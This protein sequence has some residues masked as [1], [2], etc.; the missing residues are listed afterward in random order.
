LVHQLISQQRSSLPGKQPYSCQVIRIKRPWYSLSFSELSALGLQLR[1]P[2]PSHWV[3]AF[4]GFLI[5]TGTAGP[6]YPADV[7]VT[8]SLLAR[9][10]YSDNLFYSADDVLED[11]ITRVE[12]KLQLI[13]KTEKSSLEVST[14]FPVYTYA[15]NHELNHVDQYYDL[16]GSLQFTP[17]TSISASAGYSITSSNDRDVEETGITLDIEKR[18]RQTYSIAANHSFSER[19]SASFSAS[20]L[21]DRPD[22]PNASHFQSYSANTGLTHVLNWFEI[23]TVARFNA[24]Y[25]NYRYPTSATDTWYV[26]LGFNRRIDEKWEYTMDLG[27]RYTVTAYETL[28]LL[29]NPLRLVTETESDGTLGARVLV[30]LSYKGAATQCNVTLSH[31]T[32]GSSGTSGTTNRSEVKLDLSHRFSYKWSGLLG[33]SYYLN[34]ADREDFNRSDIDERR[35]WVRPAIHYRFNNDC[36]AEFMYVLNVNQDREAGSTGYTNRFVF[37]IRYQLSLLE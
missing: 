37:L 6:T 18:W 36:R 7:E 15:D 8:A 2:R 29:T 22:D 24:G 25:A 27:P 16:A 32:A 4:L 13:R 19:T 20:F 23:P 17:L 35:L 14:R 3:A 10:E 9:E 1:P 30:N 5:V 26:N 28:R 11:W 34:T 21:D 31:D 33:V 12:P